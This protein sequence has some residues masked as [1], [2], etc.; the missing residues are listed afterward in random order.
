[1]GVVFYNYDICGVVYKALDFLCPHFVASEHLDRSLHCRLNNTLTGGNLSGGRFPA[2]LW[3]D[4]GMTWAQ[5]LGILPLPT[6]G[7]LVMRQR[8]PSRR[9]T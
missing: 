5:L 6:N 2:S 8:V 3:I 1:M 9:R 7:S 4:N